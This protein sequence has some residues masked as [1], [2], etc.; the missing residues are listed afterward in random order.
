[1]RVAVVNPPQPVVTLDDA[2]EH[3]K[4]D[5]DDDNALI[6]SMV[7]AATA[8]IDGPDGWLGRALGVQTLEA[9]LPAPTFDRILHLPFPPVVEVVQ[10]AARDGVS[11][12][13]VDS[14]AYEVRGAEVW[15]AYQ[16][17]WPA[18]AC[19][20]EA[21]RVRYR[22][23]YETLPAPIRVAILLMTAD[24]YRNRETQAAQ[25]S[26]TVDALLQPFRV[27]R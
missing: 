18:W 15:Q 12:S 20:A 8:H 22:A 17:A 24:L 26:S 4:V 27:W 3:L 14:A 1:M 25:R 11:W 2:K 13:V 21:V 23:G 9:Y 10:V 6:E 7:A 16:H 5:G 19:D